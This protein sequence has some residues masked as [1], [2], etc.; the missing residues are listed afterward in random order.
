MVIFTVRGESLKFEHFDQYWSN[1]ATE[2]QDFLPN[3]SRSY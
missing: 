2:F 3:K 1:E